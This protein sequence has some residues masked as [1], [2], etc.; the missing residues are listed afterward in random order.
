MLLVI[1]VAV[2]GFVVWVQVRGVPTYE[3]PTSQLPTLVVPATPTQVELGE[4][5]VMASCADC[6]PN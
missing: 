4:K 1:L 6:H 5:L 2:L 3:V